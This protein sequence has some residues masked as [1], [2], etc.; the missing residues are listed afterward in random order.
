MLIPNMGVDPQNKPDLMEFDFAYWERTALAYVEATLEVALHKHAPKP[1]LEAMRY[2]VLGGGKR[3]RPLLV[4]ASAQAAGVPLNSAA[5]LHAACAVELI[6]A[7]SLVHDDMPCMDNDMLRRGQPTV[8]AKFGQALALLAGDALQTLAFEVL[9][10][11]QSSELAYPAQI[12]LVALLSCAAGAGGMAGG[13]AIDL[14]HVGLALNEE[15]L[16][17][18]HQ[19]KTGKLLACCVAMGL[20]CSK[21][22]LPSKAL[23]AFDLFG[24][25]IGL[26]FQIV[27]DILDA[28]QESTV[29][30][31]TAGKD[32]QAVK[33]TYVSILGVSQ[34]QERAQILH[35][36]AQQALMDSGLTHIQ[37]MRALANRMISRSC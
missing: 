35:T 15:Q 28:T 11:I 2:A 19:L 32:A 18:M 34:A 25:H 24:Q 21:E 22:E 26:A 37:A 7:Y 33:P 30:G 10:A 20:A 5:A 31:K 16:Q 12:K 1:L 23:A 17:Q 8:H 6:H 9:T 27:D 3:L 29:L 4:L 13:Q 14:C 36:Q